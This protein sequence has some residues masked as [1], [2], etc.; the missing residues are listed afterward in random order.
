MSPEGSDRISSGTV[1]PK[2]KC[3]DIVVQELDNETLVYDLE[4][5]KAHHLN[6]TITIVWNNCDGET[7]AKEIVKRL[8]KRF[9]TKVEEDFVWL[10]LDELKRANLLDSEISKDDF[11]KLSRRKVLFRYAP[12]AVALPIVMTLI[13]PPAVHAQSCVMVGQPCVTP[14]DCCPPTT[15]IFCVGEPGTATCQNIAE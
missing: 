4:N 10:A 15:D 3:K 14:A 12:I 11:A 5:D 6:E 2:A 9:N 1:L 7:T 8:E 13:A